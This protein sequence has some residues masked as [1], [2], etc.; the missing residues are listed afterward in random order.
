MDTWTISPQQ[1]QGE[2]S[3]TTGHGSGSL[4]SSL[5]DG[6]EDSENGS[7]PTERLSSMRDAPGGNSTEPE[8]RSHKRPRVLSTTDA[9]M[10]AYLRGEATP[11]ELA[12]TLTRSPSRRRGWLPFLVVM[13]AAGVVAPVAA[14]L[15]K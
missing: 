8:R 5:S 15:L 7:L 1:L 12:L 3:T 6:S 4:R 14:S 9:H 2:S 13:L 10:L 11:L